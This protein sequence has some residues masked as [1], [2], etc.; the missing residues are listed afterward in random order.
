MAIEGIQLWVVRK[1]C[2]DACFYG[3]DSITPKLFYLLQ[4][5]IRNNSQRNRFRKRVGLPPII[6]AQKRFIKNGGEF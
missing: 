3:I 1:Q 4:A 5:A 2:L 6:D